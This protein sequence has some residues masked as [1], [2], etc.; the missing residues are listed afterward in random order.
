MY[1]SLINRHNIRGISA[2]SERAFEKQLRV[3]GAVM[4]RGVH[5][6]RTVC[7]TLWYIAGDIV[8]YHLGASSDA[9]YQLRASYALFWSAIEYFSDHGF[10][11]LSLGAGAGVRGC[12]TDGLSQFKRGWSTGTRTAYL[13]GRI[14]D[15]TRYSGI[16]Q[17]KAVPASEFFPA[18]RAGEIAE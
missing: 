14:F 3:P 16:L 17:A 9:G 2:F 4:F 10:R 1:G 8:Y 12:D 18:Y 15:P 5:D 11:R 6:G 13:C 7:M